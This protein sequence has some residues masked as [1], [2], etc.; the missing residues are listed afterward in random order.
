MTL[1]I[2]SNEEKVDLLID[3]DIYEEHAEFLRDM[4]FSYARRGIKKMDIQLGCT[5]YISSQ[6]QKCLRVMR[7]TLGRQ[8]IQ[9]SFKPNLLS[10]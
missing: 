9:V 1:Q 2:N 5:Y 8:G 4:S 6:G 7:E 10:L 3:G